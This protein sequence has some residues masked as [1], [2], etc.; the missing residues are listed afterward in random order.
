M[1]DRQFKPAQI[2]LGV[3]IV[4]Q[5]AFVIGNSGLRLIRDCGEMLDDDAL[6]RLA[7]LTLDL[8]HGK[9]PG[10]QVLQTLRRWSELTGQEQ[11]W[12]LFAPGVADQAR[13]LHI[14][15]RWNAERPAVLLRAANEPDDLRSF[16]R[17][18]HPRLRKY[19]TY[20]GA[21]LEV[22]E[23]ETPA[24]ARTRWARLIRRRVWEQSEHLQTYLWWRWRRYRDE[25]P[26]C[27]APAEII[28]HLHRWQIPE[29]DRSPW[30]LDGP[31]TV[32][33]ARFRPGAVTPHRP[34]AIDTYNPVTKQFDAIE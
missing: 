1:S 2:A 32:P 16:F 31:N 23:D 21:N 3:F 5:I 30:F 14:E 18:Q 15:L 19:E 10:E 6:A 17:W 20:L 34:L 28:L 25:N 12:S 33:F 7:H 11:G 9:G 29:V 4:W 24:Q 8:P 27:P 22:H 13:F 26:D